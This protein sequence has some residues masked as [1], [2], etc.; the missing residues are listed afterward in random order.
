MTRL[1]QRWA[2]L[3]ER[4]LDALC[5]TG[6]TRRAVRD[7]LRLDPEFHRATKL[8]LDE[9]MAH[10]DSIACLHDALDRLVREHA[11]HASE[12]S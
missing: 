1:G 10:R 9:Y 12:E 5:L 8:F 2:R 3:V 7:R 11:R 6:G 4:G